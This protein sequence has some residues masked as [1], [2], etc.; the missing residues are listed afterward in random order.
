MDG[1]GAS[2]SIDGPRLVMVL[3]IQSVPAAVGVHED[4]LFG[5]RSLELVQAPGA[6]REF[7][8]GAMI[9]VHTANIS[10]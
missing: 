10:V 3:Q 9:Y 6:G 8:I 2:K 4:L 1:A 7:A 5:H